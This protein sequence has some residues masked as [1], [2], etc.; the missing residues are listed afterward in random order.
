MELL[1][2]LPHYPSISNDSFFQDIYQKKEF[3][4]LRSRRLEGDFYSHQ[5][6]IARFISQWTLYNA[7]LLIHDTGTG[8][9]SSATA[10][11]DHLL[12]FR[13]KLKTLYLSN[14]ETLIENF[15]TE[16]LR[17][18]PILQKTWKEFVKKIAL[19]DD[20]FV[21]YRNRLLREAGVECMTY[22]R[23]ASMMTTTKSEFGYTA[24]L[25]KKYSGGFII[26]DEVHHLVVR[27]IEKSSTEETAYREVHR[28][29]HMIPDRKVLLMTATPMRNSP[30]EI[31]PLLNLVLPMNQ[32]FPR[33]DL[34]L[35]EYFKVQAKE[36]ILP[37]LEWRPGMQ[38]HF[39]KQIQGYVSVVKQNVDVNV[40]YQGRISPPMK[41]FP[42][43]FHVM[44]S[45]QTQNYSKAFIQD[46]QAALSKKKKASE[47][48]LID[49]SFYSHS[50]QASLMVFPNGRSGV[51]PSTAPY[52]EGTSNRHL[53][54]LFFQETKLKRK[55]KTPDDISYN[56][57]I[58]QTFSATYH[59]ILSQI[60]YRPYELCYV[61]CDKI[62]GSGILTCV[63]LLVQCFDFSLLRSPR[64]FQW[65]HTAR[66]CIFLN[67]T[68]KGTTK[69]DIPKLI[70]IFNDPRNKYGDF[71]Q[72]IFGTDKTREGITLK[73]IQQIHIAS[74]DWN[75]GK[76]FQAI[77]RGVRLQS[78]EGMGSDVTVR[79]F[80]HCTVPDRDVSIKTN[81]LTDVQVAEEEGP[82]EILEKDEDDPLESVPVSTVMDLEKESDS[83]SEED[84]EAWLAAITKKDILPKTED[85]TPITRQQLG[86]SI[87]FY[88][89]LRSELRDKNI[90][91]VEY[92]TLIGAMDCQLNYAD[93][94]KPNAS[95]YSAECMYEPC[96]Y[97][98]RGITDVNPVSIDEST[99]NQFYVQTSIPDIIQEIQEYFY[100]R[101]SANFDTLCTYFADKN[102]PP[103]QVVDGLHVVMGTPIPIMRSDY[104]LMYLVHDKD[105]FFLVDDRF[106]LVI[107]KPSEWTWLQSYSHE[108]S[109][110]TS[111]SFDVLLEEFVYYPQVLEPFLTDMMQIEDPLLLKEIWERLPWRIQ[112][113][114]LV[115]IMRILEGHESIVTDETRKWIDNA[116]ESFLRNILQK[117][118]E[119]WEYKTV[120]AS[121]ELD[122]E[123]HSRFIVKQIQI[124]FLDIP[125]ETDD[126]VEDHDEV[127]FIDKYVT[128]NPIK[129][130]GFMDAKG[131]KIRDVSKDEG[132]VK[133]L[134]SKTRGKECTSYS[135]AELLFFLWKLGER[136][137]LEPFPDG[138]KTDRDRYENASQSSVAVLSALLKDI[139]AWNEQFLNFMKKESLPIEDS[140]QR[141][142]F[143]F[144]KFNRAFLCV[145][146]KQKLLEQNLLVK[147]PKEIKKSKKLKKK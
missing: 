140:T 42:L 50:V 43:A 29:L 115:Q 96:R 51:S 45:F 34:F 12:R 7:L 146:L 118:E 147:P 102:I 67:D 40:Q 134:K 74:P 71:V 70:E 97:T 19:D 128:N 68:E 93:N 15:K 35:Q 94:Q 36:S 72:V 64:Q 23:F 48:L 109:F 41:Y 1:E 130:Y 98:C 123:T 62:N 18:S 131:F 114:V 21:L 5:K 69:A 135:T 20:N 27:Q 9:S 99:F 126:S 75:F 90:K 129:L 38:N 73:R 92:A 80:L 138:K 100:N 31:A 133:D 83:D 144:H 103:N 120:D 82:S 53:S 143:Y 87:D 125:P 141:M 86:T 54:R 127:Q 88:R 119:G 28:F 124:D 107:S 32:Q 132:Q 117:S 55:A 79:L 22:A 26:L 46:T 57:K 112:E 136:L 47:K 52:F 59:A 3:Y 137:P 30:S 95:D 106:S 78:H 8:K 24:K 101:F 61:Y 2:Y 116:L 44:S 108:P 56:L 10:V 6:I 121:Y 110:D 11:F 104:R 111:L 25:V 66:R 17:R 37:I 145:R 49:G 63:M 4:D 139:S 81:L 105:I 65:S 142:F 122:K 85:T 77:G 58:L 60:I 16:M 76:I 13:P 91:L 84:D 113:K 33:G 39:L 14:N 89:Y